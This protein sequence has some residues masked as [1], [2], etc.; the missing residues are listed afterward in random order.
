MGLL[1]A[2]QAHKGLRK[3]T[4]YWDIETL[5]YNKIE[6]RKQPTDY[7]NVVYSVAVGWDNQGTIDVEVFPSFNSFFKTFFKYAERKDTI[8]KSRTSIEMIAHNC[9]KYDNHFLLHDIQ[10]IYPNVKVENL[11]MKSAETN[12]N[13]V[14][15]KEAKTDAK[16]DN[17]VLE[18]RVK[19]SINLDLIFFLQGFKFVVVDNFMKTTTS[20]ATL[21]KKLKDGGYLTS[22]QLKTDFQYDIFDI[23]EDMDDVES[24]AYAYECF[25]KL[26]NDQ[27]TYIHNDVIILGQ[28]H[29]HYSDI[30]P[31][32]DYS[33]MT[34]SV[35]ILES[36]MNNDFTG[37]QLLNK[38]GDERISYTDYHFHNRNLYDYIKGFYNGGLNMYNPKYIGQI[39]N[40]PCFSIDIN[41]SYPYVM[42]HEK[43]PT[44]LSS[45]DEFESETIVYTNLDNYDKFTLYKMTKQSFNFDILF[46]IES[47]MIKKILVKYYATA[48]KEDKDYININTN[49][50]RM[51]EDLTDLDLSRISTMSYLTFDC[52]YFGAR[53]IIHE[54]YFIKT[55]GKL[56][57]KID[58]P[59][60]YDYTI[61]DEP[62]ETVYSAEEVMLSKVVLNGLY[63][64]PALRSHFNLFR[65]DED[66]FLY[67][68]INGYK[69]TERNILFSTFVTSQ[70]LY[71]LLEPLQDL[72]QKEIDDN[73]IYCDT[74]SLYLKSA[75]KDK[76]DASIFDPISLG[77]WDV[78]NDRIE[79]M[80]VL[81]HKKYAYLKPNGK[82]HVA[83]AGVPLDAFNTEQ[84]F[85][86]FINNDFHHG[87]VIYNNKSIYNKQGTISIYPSE[88]HIEMGQDYP[89]YFSDMLEEEKQQMFEEIRQN[90]DPTDYEDILYIESSLGIFSINDI[91][92][93]THPI[94]EA[95]N[96]KILKMAHEQ[97][98]TTSTQ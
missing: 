71:N 85:E 17:I 96:I 91:Y 4:L 54:N 79:K 10:H 88:T 87:A 51:I 7:K 22:D 63:G 25:K 81:N 36:Y 24:Y 77:K 76:I 45:Y 59:T 40:E 83:S 26:D 53:D 90:Y 21:G 62:N 48:L 61:T 82:I 78:E 42:Y 93:V 43:I 55:Q 34:F 46:H 27:M 47:D 6:G 69:N 86:D 41:S 74:D 5:A 38:I 13:T 11:F 29:I 75:I 8:T 30:F 64:I 60:P 92:P 66:G 35:N 72:T 12:E 89:T 50:L 18:K 94:D 3:M 52:E 58:M 33:K 16:E 14:N 97:I 1:E 20:I 57:T 15:M 73:F 67:N 49:T 2:M 31:N 44:Y 32:F 84:S 65:K 9:N 28:C 98:K 19:S 80:Y 70:S 39:I 95:T 23:E 68:M 56:K 37:F